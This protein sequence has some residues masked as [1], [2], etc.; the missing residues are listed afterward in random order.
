MEKKHNPETGRPRFP[1]IYCGNS[2]WIQMKTKLTLKPGQKGTK[3]LCEK[4][5]PSLVCVRYRYDTAG[6]KRYKT[7]ELIEEEIQWTPLDKGAPETP[8][9]IVGKTDL[10]LFPRE[11]AEKY[12]ADDQRIMA[13]G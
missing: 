2:S 1:Y 9:E 6:K 10:E 8:D 11:L 4:Y 3:K 5:G 7:V 12:R 13:A